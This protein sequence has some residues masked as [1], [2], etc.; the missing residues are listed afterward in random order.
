[1]HYFAVH[2]QEN[3]H[4]MVKSLYREAAVFAL[5]LEFPISNNLN[6]IIFIYFCKI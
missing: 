6:I 3:K 5:A 2:A 1:M 4:T